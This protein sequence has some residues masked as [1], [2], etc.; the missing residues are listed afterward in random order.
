MKKRNRNPALQCCL[1]VGCIGL[2]LLSGC[3]GAGEPRSESRAASLEIYDVLG[4]YFDAFNR[5]DIEEITAAWHAPGWFSLGDSVRLLDSKDQIGQLYQQLLEK[6]KGEGFDHSE[7]LS[8]EIE[9]LNETAALCRITFTRL[10]S[11]GQF[12][13]PRVR[14]ALL[15]LLKVDGRWG[16]QSVSLESV[17]GRESAAV[18]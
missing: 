15:K 4:R 7:L 6:I 2:I 1:F 9:I 17:P 13:P 11:D 16:I 5:A 3:A 14:G 8:E 10:K 12:M 18:D